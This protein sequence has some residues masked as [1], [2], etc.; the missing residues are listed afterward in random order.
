MRIIFEHEVNKY[1]TALYEFYELY[2]R[3]LKKHGIDEDG[4]ELTSDQ[5]E[6]CEDIA[7]RFFEVLEDNKIDYDDVFK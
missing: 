7:E 1:R 4:K 5:I 3:K 2:L 6:I